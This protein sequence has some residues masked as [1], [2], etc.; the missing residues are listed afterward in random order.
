MS[1]TSE[2]KAS[3]TTLTATVPS[4]SSTLRVGSSVK[5]GRSGLSGSTW[6]VIV[7]RERLIVAPLAS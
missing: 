3:W 1:V 6:I 2:A 5:V 7:T 4:S